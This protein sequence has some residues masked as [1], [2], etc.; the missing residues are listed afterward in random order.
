MSL[1]VIVP[2]QVRAGRAL[3]G[4]SQEQLA[5]E[6]EI[7]LSSV[8]DTESERRAADTGAVASIRRALWNGG[9]VF[10]AGRQG[11]GPGVRLVAN[12][13]NIIR[14][15]TTVQTF[16]GMPFAV[17]WQ[18]KV[19]TVFVAITVLDDL[20]GHRGHPTEG[21]YFKT[22]ERHRGEILDAVAIA[23]T[24]PD[25]FDQFGR[26]YLRQKD[27]DALKVG[28]W[29]QVVIDGGEDVRDTSA[30]E[31]MRKFASIFISAG[32]PS[33]VEVFRD[34]RSVESHVYYFSPGASYMANDLLASFNATP[35]AALPDFAALRKV[36]L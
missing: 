19:V 34:L 3:L 22:F 17:E 18:G 2:A 16:E 1:D 23:I 4:W 35:C 36:R 27:L 7:G 9:V 28:Q 13:P 24:D 10:T 15:P 6:A 31:F 26:L 33:T 11:E 25:N 12:R 14:R 21:E 32:I 30:R 29:H 8:R 5:Q 20:D